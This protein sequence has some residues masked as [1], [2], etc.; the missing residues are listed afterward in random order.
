VNH[1]FFAPACCGG[2]FREYKRKKISSQSR[3]GA[4]EGSLSAVAESHTERNTISLRLPAVGRALR[5]AHRGGSFREDKKY[6]ARKDA[7]ASG[8]QEV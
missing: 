1:N 7:K 5:P 6:L 8:W 3:E 2:S 4:K